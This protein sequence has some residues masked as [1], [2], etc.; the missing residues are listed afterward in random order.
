MQE[1]HYSNHHRNKYAIV[2]VLGFVK[3]TLGWEIWSPV[4]LGNASPVELEIEMSSDGWAGVRLVDLAN[5]DTE[6]PVMHI[7]Y[8]VSLGYPACC[9]DSDAWL[10]LEIRD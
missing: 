9:G 2:S 10:Y 1:K 6:H 7:L 5:K 8:G 4:E 3:D